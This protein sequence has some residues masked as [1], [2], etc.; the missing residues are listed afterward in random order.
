MNPTISGKMITYAAHGDA[1]EAEEEELIHAGDNDSPNNT[2]DP[3]AQ[4]GD[5]HTRVVGVSDRRANLGIGR[6]ILW[7]TR[8]SWRVP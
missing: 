2:N 7:T 6:V 4:G 3:D 1:R 8:F 5:R